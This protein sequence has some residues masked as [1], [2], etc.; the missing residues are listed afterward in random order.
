[1]LMFDDSSFEVFDVIGLDDRMAAIR[2]KIQPIFAEI[3][4]EVS[5]RLTAFTGNET[6]VHIAQH[7]RRTKYAPEN[8]WAAISDNKRG[9]K[10]QAHLQLGIWGDYIFMYL[11]IIDNPVNRVAY[12]EYLADHHDFPSDF[13]YSLDHTKADYFSVSEELETGIKRLHD[14]KK[15]EFEVGRVILRKSKIWQETPESY[16]L[17]TFELLFPL[18]QALNA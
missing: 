4:A 9:Y 7:R 14:V 13:V 15:G 6:F 3:M 12:A 1:M 2:S 5:H 17:E 16:I 18:Y 10:S 11:S 8:T